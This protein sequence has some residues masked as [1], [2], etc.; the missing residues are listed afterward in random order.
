MGKIYLAYLLDSVNH[1]NSF[2]GIKYLL[3]LIVTETVSPTG[4]ASLYKKGYLYF[5][6]IKNS[7]LK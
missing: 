1:K 6:L 4:Y 3:S 5:A 2:I 7:Q